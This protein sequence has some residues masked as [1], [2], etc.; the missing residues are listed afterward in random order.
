[1]STPEY[2]PAL[3]PD[4]VEVMKKCGFQVCWWK[5]LGTFFS[6][7]GDAVP[8]SAAIKWTAWLLGA[9]ECLI[10]NV[11]YTIPPKWTMVNKSSGKY[12]LW[13]IVDSA[14]MIRFRVYTCTVKIVDPPTPLQGALALNQE[15]QD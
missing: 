12:L 7:I 3:S 14:N 15:H 13:E 9:Q 11:P 5:E 4:V 2:L 6:Q 8:P 1:M 10:D